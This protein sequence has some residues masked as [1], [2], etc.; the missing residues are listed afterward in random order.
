MKLRVV[1]TVAVVVALSL[2]GCG[3]TKG[4]GKMVNLLPLITTS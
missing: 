3:I 4:S 1:A 2:A